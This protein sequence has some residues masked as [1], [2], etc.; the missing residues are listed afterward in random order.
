MGVFH[1]S[2]EDE[3]KKNYPDSY[4]KFLNKNI[5][6]TCPNGESGRYIRLSVMNF[7]SEVI[8]KPYDRVA[9]IC[10]GGVIRSIL[11]HFLKIE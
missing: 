7:L 10:H 6:F 1:T 4:T 9:I 5:D 3:I 8:D 11:C 2:T